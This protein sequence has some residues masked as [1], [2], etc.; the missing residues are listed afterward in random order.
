MKASNKHVRTTMYLVAQKCAQIGPCELREF[1]KRVKKKRNHHV[2]TIALARRLMV[3]VWNML[4]EKTVFRDA[5]NRDMRRRKEERYRRE[6]RRLKKLKR[7]IGTEEFIGIVKGLLNRGAE[8]VPTE[9]IHVWTKL[10]T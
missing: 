5:Y 4:R 2:A 6:V 9:G 8:V 7:E 10:H 1:H 3:V